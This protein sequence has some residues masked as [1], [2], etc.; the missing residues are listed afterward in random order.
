MTSVS[1][2]SQ[3]FTF[4]LPKLNTFY[5]LE[6]MD[7]VSKTQLQVGENSNVLIRRLKV[8]ISATVLHHVHISSKSIEHNLGLY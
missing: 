1:K 8:H 6:V 3:S 4:I 7:R 2:I 5:S